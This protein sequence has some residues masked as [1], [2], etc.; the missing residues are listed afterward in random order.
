MKNSKKSDILV[1]V[2]AG[3]AVCMIGIVI[4]L[5]VKSRQPA[6]DV[7][8]NATMSVSQTVWESVTASLSDVFSTTGE[9][10]AA[11]PTQPTSTA[12]STAAS[13]TAADTTATQ[14]GE[15]TTYNQLEDT[16]QASANSGV[17]VPSN[18]KDLPA[19]MS[20]AGLS[21]KGY[22]VIGGK[23]YIYN[24]DKNPNSPQRR[25]GFNRIYDSL[26][27]VAD[28]T[29][30]TVRLQF[31]YGGKDWMIQL[32]KGQYISGDI[33][34]VGGEVG[35]YTRPEGTVSAIG[36]Y[37][38][39]EE[40]D[41]LYLECTCFWDEALNGNYL[42]QYTRNYNKYWWA[43]GYVDGQLSNKR[44]NNELRLLTR[45]TFKSVDMAK[46]FEK[47]LAGEGFAATENF[48]PY[49]VETYKRSGKDVIFVWQNAR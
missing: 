36:H 8:G 29:I 11:L 2:V 17:A 22:N 40:E 6:I 10:S 24:N 4:A 38:C 19:D 9:T 34:T 5:V 26:A 3:L 42:P 18:N 27:G 32:W 35:I 41:W 23:A 16:Q 39:A 43:T 47:A 7:E 49:A 12:A 28:F 46:E 21:G 48:N 31:V 30:E 20:F 33:G 14:G 1:I 25:F 37:S 44:N 45:I 15:T 13:T